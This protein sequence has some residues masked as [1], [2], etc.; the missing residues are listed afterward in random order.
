MAEILAMADVLF[1]AS[2]NSITAETTINQIKLA[3]SKGDKE[4]YFFWSAKEEEKSVL[5]IKPTGKGRGAFFVNTT[6]LQVSPIRNWTWATSE[7]TSCQFTLLQ[8][9][10]HIVFH[11]EK[12]ERKYI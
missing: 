5:H 6:P 3:I 7:T 12:F 8:K 4:I 10:N 11:I 1:K 2:P 9:K